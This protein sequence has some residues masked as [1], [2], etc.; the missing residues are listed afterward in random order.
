MSSTGLRKHLPWAVAALVLSAALFMPQLLMLA[1]PLL[2]ILLC[3]LLMWT[4][5]RGHGHEPHHAH[6]AQQEADVE[7]LKLR[8]Q[9][10]EAELE[11][12]RREKGRA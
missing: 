5:M 8:Q 9:E 4:M 11:S 6:D 12:L 1:L 3:P 10:L 2:L 7:R